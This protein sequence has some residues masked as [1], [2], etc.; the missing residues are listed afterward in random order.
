MRV[1]KAHLL[2]QNVVEK[3]VGAQPVDLGHVVQVGQRD[4]FFARVCG[5]LRAE[6]HADDLHDA[7]V[8]HLRRQA[9]AAGAEATSGPRKG[10]VAD[11]VVAK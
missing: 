2:Q 4:G 10:R 1:P 5:L 11:I 8:D 7:A 6:D 3:N 9:R